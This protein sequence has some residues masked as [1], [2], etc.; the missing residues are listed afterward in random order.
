M[1][2]PKELRD[3]IAALGQRQT[4]GSE[5]DSAIEAEDDGWNDAIG[6]VLEILDKHAAKTTAALEQRRAAGKWTGGNIPYGRQLAPDGETLIAHPEEQAVIKL[7]KQLRASGQTFRQIAHELDKR[8]HASRMGIKF[9]P[10]A[11]SR[12]MR[13]G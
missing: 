6:A 7:A 3:E 13:E 1:V 2:I 5:S 9:R 4:E 8:G 10:F 12:L 11:I